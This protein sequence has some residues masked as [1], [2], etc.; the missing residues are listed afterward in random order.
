MEVN[1]NS[2]KWEAA[3]ANGVDS[4]F[5]PD[6]ITKYMKEKYRHPAIYRWDIFKDEPD[7]MKT[8]YVGETNKLCNRVGQYLKPGK[9]QQTDK[10]LNKKFHRYIAEGCNVRLEIL[11]FDEI[12]IGDS[13]FNY[14]DIS[15]SEEDFGKFFRWFVEDLMVVIYKK[16]GF[17]VLNKP[18]RK[19]KT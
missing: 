8:I 3:S 6:E 1:V 5:F 15:K 18:G 12:K 4:Y 19:G 11:Q 17:N 9:A 14:S 16:K 13:T 2:Y 7:D 10:E